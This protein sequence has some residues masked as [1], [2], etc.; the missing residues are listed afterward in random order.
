MVNC[1]DLGGYQA[2]GGAPSHGGGCSA[3]ATSIRRTAS[4]LNRLKEELKLLR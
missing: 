2:E 4:D 3:A 1:R